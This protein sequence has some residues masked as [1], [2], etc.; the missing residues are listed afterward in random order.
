MFLDSSAFPM[1]WMRQTAQSGAPAQE[2][3]DELA[4][5]LARKQVFVF[6]SEEGFNDHDHAQ[7]E[8]KQTALW[9]KQ[10]KVEIRA[11]IKAM[12][13]IEPNAAKRLASKAFATMF[14]KFWGYPLLVVAAR[15]EAMETASRLL[16]ADPKDGREM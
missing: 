13:L 15:D 8:R 2:P 1:V 3:F 12:I 9:M 6:L 4:N 10:H 5:L 11:F 16:G 7:D 14:V